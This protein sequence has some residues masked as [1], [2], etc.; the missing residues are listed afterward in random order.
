MNII[1]VG[2]S[3]TSLTLANLLSEDH[4]VTIIEHEEDKAHDIANKTHAL[5]VFA[6]GS[7]ITALKEAGLTETDVL[8]ALTDDKTNLMVC[9]I[10][11]SEH[12]ERIISLVHEPK[13][14]ELFIKLGITNLISVVGTNVTAIKRMLD[15]VTGDVR[16]IAQLGEGDLQILEVPIAEKSKLIGKHPTIVNASIAAIYRSGEL[17]I[18]REDTSFEAGDIL[19]VVVETK[20]VHKVIDIIRGK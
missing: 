15:Q 5:V 20:N 7:D 12:I 1:I 18:T 19:L 10:A 9:Q 14:E 11:M 6:D 17:H 4:K 3:I 13:N 2:G 8:I 16:F